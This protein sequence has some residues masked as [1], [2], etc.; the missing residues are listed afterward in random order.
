MSVLAPS[1]FYAFAD[2]TM[3]TVF[4]LPLGSE[5]LLTWLRFVGVPK[6]CGLLSRESTLFS[7]A[8]TKSG[9]VFSSTFSSPPPTF[10]NSSRVSRGRTQPQRRTNNV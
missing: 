8:A 5:S 10:S 9:C 3:L 2:E 7:R 1:T 6:L 4:Q